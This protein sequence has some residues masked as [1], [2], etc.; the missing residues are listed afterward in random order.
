MQSSTYI[1]NTTDVPR[2]VFIKTNFSVFHD[3]DLFWTSLTSVNLC[4]THFE[5]CLFL[6]TRV[7]FV[8]IRVRLVLTG[9]RLVLRHADSCRTH[10]RIDLVFEFCII[11]HVLFAFFSLYTNDLLTDKNFITKYIPLEKFWVP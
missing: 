2:L 1:K 6:L 5:L 8:L 11:I 3:L 7:R 9:V 4:R 10:I